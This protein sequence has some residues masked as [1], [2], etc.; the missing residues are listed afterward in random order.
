MGI[1]AIFVVPK[2][3]SLTFFAIDCHPF[4]TRKQEFHDNRQRVIS[5][6]A[7]FPGPVAAFTRLL[8]SALGNFS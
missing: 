5:A 4:K 1:E 2:E 6:C 8:L 3:R 7:D